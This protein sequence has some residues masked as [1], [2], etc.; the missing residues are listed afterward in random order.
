MDEC[1]NKV[2]E[3]VG[4]Q[5]GQPPMVPPMRYRRVGS[6]TRVTGSHLHPG[7]VRNEITYRYEP[8]LPEYMDGPP[9]QDYRG[10][11]VKSY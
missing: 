1:G 10:F 9:G 6:S 3:L 5:P 8:L 7:G 4:P 11:D 2:R